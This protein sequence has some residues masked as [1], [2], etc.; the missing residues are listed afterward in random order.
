VIAS[1]ILKTSEFYQL[2]NWKKLFKTVAIK[3]LSKVGDEEVYVVVATPL[4]GNPITQYISTKS[5]LILKR[6]L[7][8]ASS[9][10]EG[11]E[12]VTE[13]YS[14][15]KTVDGVVLPFKTVSHSEDTGDT[16]MRVKAVKFDVEIPDSAFRAQARNVNRKS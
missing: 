16:V 1:R 10:G 14:D 4:K 8:T 12:A 15:Y 11:A 2:V 7:L 9:T 13:T 5:F 6:D 3:K